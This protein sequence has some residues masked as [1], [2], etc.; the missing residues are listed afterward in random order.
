[1]IDFMVAATRSFFYGT[2]SVVVREF[3]TDGLMQLPAPGAV[4]ERN[5]GSDSDY[6]LAF[7]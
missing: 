6:A 2:V 1:M 5:R 4:A 3:G 7:G